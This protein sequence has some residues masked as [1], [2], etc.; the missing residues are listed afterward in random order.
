MSE[1]AKAVRELADLVKS[2]LPFH[3]EGGAGSSHKGSRHRGG[4]TAAQHSV[5]Q[6]VSHAHKFGKELA[7]R[8]QTQAE[9]DRTTN[10]RGGRLE[11]EHMTPEA[12][13]SRSLTG[14]IAR[15][16]DYDIDAMLEFCGNLLEEVNAHDEAKKVRDM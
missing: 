3:L 16:F 4:A 1:L 9:Y 7:D 12:T 15:H 2:Q 11:P 5:N 8:V 6:V 10:L 14:P 13:L